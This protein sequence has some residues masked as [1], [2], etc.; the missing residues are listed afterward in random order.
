MPSL[1]LLLSYLIN[2]FSGHTYIVLIL[3]KMILNI[4]IERWK[5]GLYL[6]HVFFNHC[7]YILFQF[8]IC[9][10]LRYSFILPSGNASYI[11]YVYRARNI[12]DVTV[13]KQ[14]SDWCSLILIKKI[15]LS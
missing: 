8:M 15:G 13:S 2:L 1:A 12:R 3:K 11:K 5:L 9:E 7:L 10:R 14:I 6:K 4:Y